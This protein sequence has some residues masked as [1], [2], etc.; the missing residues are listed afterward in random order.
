MIWF[1]D[2]NICFLLMWPYQAR[3]PIGSALEMPE[4]KD[5]PYFYELDIEF[6]EVGQIER[7]QMADVWVDVRRQVLDGLVSVAECH[8]LLS[9]PLSEQTQS[10]NEAVQNEL[11][12]WLADKTGYAVDQLAETYTIIMIGDPGP[13][14]QRLLPGKA[15]PL[16]RLLRNLPQSLEQSDAEA[17]LSA[18]A[19]YSDV[20]LTVVDWSGAL[21]IAPDSDFDSDV[22]LLKMGKYQILRYRMMDQAV[23]SM[24]QAVRRQVSRRRP[25]WLSRPNHTIRA[26]VERRLELLLDFERIDQS[27]LLIGDWYSAEVYGLIVDRFALDD[28]Q[29]LVRAKL[30]NLETIDQVVRET[31]SFSWRRAIDFVMFVG[32][33]VLL[34]GYFY[35][36]FAD[37]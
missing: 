20:D 4:P 9:G 12:A 17:V 31:L 19:R 7:V 37:L 33:I 29:G 10:Q 3:S 13:E 1:V 30:D 35:L 36:F 23:Q 2:L 15:I 32:W 18:R 14:G 24:L 25:G 22:P 16:A 11:R 28:W 27:L 26:I 21:L 34:V 6:R 5:A 8:Y